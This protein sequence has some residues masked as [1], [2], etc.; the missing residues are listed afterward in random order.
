[1]E[2]WHEGIYAVF[3]RLLE[4]RGQ[5]C[6]LFEPHKLSSKKELEGEV[7]KNQEVEEEEVEQEEEKEEGKEEVEEEEVHRN[8]DASISHEMLYPGVAP[9]G[10]LERERQGREEAKREAGSEKEAKRRQGVKLGK[11]RGR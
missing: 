3:K 9:A 7:H 8:Q 11:G 2:V 10:K 5:P 1:M 6:S 4:I